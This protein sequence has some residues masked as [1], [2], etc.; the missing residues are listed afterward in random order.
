[1][2]RLTGLPLSYINRRAAWVDFSAYAL[3]SVFDEIVVFSRFPARKRRESRWRWFSLLLACRR[4]WLA[5]QPWLLS[6]FAL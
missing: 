4:Y 1:M 6:L 2:V 3:L 5:T